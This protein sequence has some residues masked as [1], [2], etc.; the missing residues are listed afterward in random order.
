[1]KKSDLI[2]QMALNAEMKRRCG[3]H[4]DF[5]KLEITEIDGDF[6]EKLRSLSD[7]LPN[8]TFSQK[9][10]VLGFKRHKYQSMGKC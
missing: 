5:V 2:E 7:G 10:I 8:V 4:V 6:E 1:M 9:S 3:K